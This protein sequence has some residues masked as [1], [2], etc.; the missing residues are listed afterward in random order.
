MD[1]SHLNAGSLYH[2]IFKNTSPVDKNF[3]FQQNKWLSARMTD[4]H[5]YIGEKIYQ[6][7][8]PP[9]E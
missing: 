4:S 5:G 6:S 8:I 2:I 3:I 9:A 1:T 7:I